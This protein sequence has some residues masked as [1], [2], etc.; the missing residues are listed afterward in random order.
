VDVIGTAK[1]IYQSSA[2]QEEI[3][4][5]ISPESLNGRLCDAQKT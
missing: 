3:V 1:A 5:A 2:L 4:L